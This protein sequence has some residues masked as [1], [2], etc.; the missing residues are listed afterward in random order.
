[1]WIY[2]ESGKRYVSSAVDL[3]KWLRKYYIPSELKRMNNYIYRVL[4]LYWHNS[5][6]LTILEYIDILNL[7]T[8]EKH[9]MILEHEQYYLNLMF[10][11]VNPNTYNILKITGSY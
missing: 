6:S 8:K 5:F 4:L 2:T 9:K 1:M 10:S 11:E 7:S 3:S